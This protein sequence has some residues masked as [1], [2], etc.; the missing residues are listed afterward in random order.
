MTDEIVDMMVKQTNHN[1][2]HSETHRPRN[3]KQ[4]NKSR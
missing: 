4:A 2:Q 3:L 1:I